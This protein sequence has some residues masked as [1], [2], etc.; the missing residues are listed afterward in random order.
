MSSMQSCSV[1]RKWKAAVER[2]FAT[3]HLKKTWLCFDPKPIKP[4]AG[5]N[6]RYGAYVEF[7][8]YCLDPTDSAHAILE[9]YNYK[10][11]IEEA[12]GIGP[13]LERPN[14]I[15][16]V[17]HQINDTVLPDVRY[18][19]D[20]NFDSKLEVSF[21]W[22]G[23]YCHFFRELRE[24]QKRLDERR[25]VIVPRMTSHSISLL[26]SSISHDVRGERIRRSVWEKEGRH[27]YGDYPGFDKLEQKRSLAECEGAYSDEGEAVGDEDELEY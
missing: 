27:A 12:L 14:M 3:K 17:R 2:V 10:N 22:K 8:F 26:E 13:S 23:M 18:L 6:V 9:F 7:Q 24:V 11:S 5:T 4:R 25:V 19:P 16:P 1:S 20:S 15:I 21:D